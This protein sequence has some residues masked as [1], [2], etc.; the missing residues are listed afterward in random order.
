[1]PELPEVETVM[2]GLQKAIRG[3]KIK[4][5]RLNRKDLRIPFPPSL[6]RLAGDTVERLSRRAKY[7][8]IHLK[9]GKTMIVHLGMSGRMTVNGAGDLP[10]DHMIVGFTDKSCF[11]FNDPRR[12]G[13]VDLCLK[14]DIV[15][16]RFFRHLGPE[17]FDEDFSADYLMQ[18][19]HGKK[20]AVKVALMDQ[21][22]VVG[23]GNIYA[24][25]ALFDAG[26]S[27][28]RAG[29]KITAREAG[30]LVKA[31]RKVLKK[32]IEAGG[33]SLRDYVQADGEMGYFQY[34]FKVYDRAGETC[35]RKACHGIVMRT[36]QAGRSTFS[37][38]SC[39]K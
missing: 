16:H 5:I 32:A 18:K 20:M 11:V 38:T 22:L 2:R 14:R 13:M 36:V 7:I 39:Q 34:G 4:Q 6:S 19:L 28:A 17:P 31:I 9:S 29:K 15:T 23:V 3:K 37:C 1:M 8:L 24:S 30:L 35:K 21:R 25:E 10:H 26:I 12:F 27:P 33:S